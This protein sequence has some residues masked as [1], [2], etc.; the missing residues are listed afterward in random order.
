MT[1]LYQKLLVRLMPEDVLEAI[2]VLHEE[3]LERMRSESRAINRYYPLYPEE[4]AVELI[5]ELL[6]AARAA[7]WR[8]VQDQL[9]ECFSDAPDYDQ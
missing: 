2:H 3:Q 4:Q 5:D 8:S 9:S 6:D 1:R 7:G